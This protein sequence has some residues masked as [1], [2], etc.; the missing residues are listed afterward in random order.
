MVRLGRFISALLVVVANLALAGMYAHGTTEPQRLAILVARD[1][2]SGTTRPI[3]DVPVILPTRCV[4]VSSL[5]AQFNVMKGLRA[6]N[7]DDENLEPQFRTDASSGI[8]LVQSERPQ[9]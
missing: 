9:I 5:R 8:S 4:R 1:A 7:P 3:I 2:P 6:C